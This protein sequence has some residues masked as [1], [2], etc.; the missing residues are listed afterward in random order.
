MDLRLWINMHI[1]LLQAADHT[2][3]TQLWIYALTEQQT[4]FRVAL[5][6]DAQ[7]RIPTR[8]TAESFTLGAFIGTQLVGTVSLDRETRFKTRHK[9]VLLRMFVHPAAT[10]QGVGKALVQ[11]TLNLAGNI[12][13]LRQVY[14]TVLATNPRAIGLYAAMGFSQFAQEPGS[15]YINGEYVDELQLVCF[16]AK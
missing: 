15:V 7:P 1:R 11:E 10:G 2:E 8:F 6:D 5:E 16:L 3:Y 12:N 4:Y 14:L 9:A 13:G